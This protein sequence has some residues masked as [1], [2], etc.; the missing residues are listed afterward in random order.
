MTM[1]RIPQLY[2]GTEV[3]MTST[4]GERDDASYRRDFPGGWAGDRVDAFQG[5][6]LDARQRAAQEL[7]RKLAT[8]RKGEPVIHSGKLMHFGPEN[9][10]W[11][12]FRYNENKRIMIAMN[13][14][15]KEMVLPTARFQEIL[16]GVTSGTDILSG[17]AVD[18]TRE[19]RLAPKA[20]LVI[21]LP[22]A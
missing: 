13:D 11:V 15:P 5:K 6:G 8:W 4:V 7:V 17:R 2:Y 12:Y 20:T 9:N 1:P 14:N 18:L 10:T 21:E 19:L 22:G 16:K 3:L